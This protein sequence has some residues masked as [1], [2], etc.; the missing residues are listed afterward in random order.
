MT[1]FV[2]LGGA[3][4]ILLWWAASRTATSGALALTAGASVLMGAFVAAAPE[5]EVL[6]AV[7]G[8]GVLS[9]AAPL[10]TVL[11]PLPDMSEA[12]AP[13]RLARQAA[14]RLALSAVVCAVCAATGYLAVV[15]GATLYLKL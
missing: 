6:T 14:H 7:L 11:F 1:L 15:V 5:S 10:L 8:F 3:F 9:T 2:A 12:G 4:G 13:N